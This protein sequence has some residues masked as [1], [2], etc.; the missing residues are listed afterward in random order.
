MLKFAQPLGKP[1]TPPVARTMERVASTADDRNT[2][3]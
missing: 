2:S 1:P 3:V